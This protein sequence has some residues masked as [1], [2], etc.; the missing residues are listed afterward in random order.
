MNCQQIDKYIYEFCDKQL[1]PQMH[2]GIQAHLDQCESCRDK[3]TAADQEGQLLRSMDII[4]A[5]GPEFT[6]RVLAA[7]KQ[8][9]G[10]AASAAF[11]A[12]PSSRYP[13]QLRWWW[14]A[15][16]AAVLLLALC[17]L[18]ML[19]M[20]MPLGIKLAEQ[21][22][23][24]RAPVETA[25]LLVSPSA[26][27]K[28]DAEPPQTVAGQETTDRPIQNAQQDIAKKQ[29]NSATKRTDA[30]PPEST[31]PSQ[32]AQLYTSAARQ[33]QMVRAPIYSSPNRG[34]ELLTLHPVNLPPEY[35]LQ[36]VISNS[37]QEITFVYLNQLTRQ[38]L[39]L[40][41]T[42]SVEAAE[43]LDQ[44]PDAP[45]LLRSAVPQDVENSEGSA[46]PAE[47]VIAHN[48]LKARMDYNQ[49]SYE[50]VLSG[51]VDDELLAAIADKVKLEEGHKGVKTE[52]P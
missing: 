4:P 3:V 7:V 38:E 31:Q 49:Q 14:G 42:A 50:M 33:E 52:N 28:S 19:N 21:S 16:G 22:A 17:S 48:S 29:Q 45:L 18:P 15:A 2:D 43:E 41:L 37:D 32:T 8:K 23:A 10:G 11:L 40:R 24:D 20:Q 12:G 27:P 13:R 47:T 35:S 51:D 1:S 30:S 39:N 44:A 5:L 6:D 25:P 34:T 46:Q 36:K 26:S 9:H